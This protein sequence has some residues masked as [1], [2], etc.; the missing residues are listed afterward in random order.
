MGL[1]AFP[2]MPA[3]GV[4]DIVSKINLSVV[5]V[6]N[7]LAC[8]LWMSG[9]ARAAEGV[10]VRETFLKQYP[11]ARFYESG[12]RVTR[13]YGT[14]MSSG[15]SAE[16]SATHFVRRYSEMLGA[17]LADL[18]ETGPLADGRH[19]QG[20]MYDAATGT[21]KF[22][23]V[24]YTQRRGGIPVYESD[25]RLLVRN[26]EGHPLVLAANGL[27]DLGDFEV[28]PLAATAAQRSINS[29][30]AKRPELTRFSNPDLVIF[31]GVDDQIVVPR[32]AHRFVGDDGKGAGLV[33]SKWEVLADA[34]TGAILH[35][36]NLIADAEIDGSVSA[37]VSDGVGASDC[38]DLVEEP[39]PYLNVTSGGSSAEA[40]EFG[41]FTLT[42]LPDGVNTI[43]STLNGRYF[44]VITDVGSVSTESV[45]VSDGEVATILHDGSET[46]EDVLSQVNAYLHSNIARD[47]TLRF[48]PDY[49]VISDQFDFTVRTNWQGVICP[50]NAQYTGDVIRFCRQTSGC[51]NMA[52]SVVVHHEYGH[53]LVQTAGSGQG[54]Y[55]EGMGDTIGVLITDDPRTG[56]GFQGNCGSALRSA[57]NNMQ[58]PCK[59]PI[60]TC[61]TLLSGCVWDTRNALA[62][63]HP[64][65]FRDIISNLAIN[66]MLLHIGSSITPQIT[67][68][69]LTL[70]DDDAQLE[71]G[72]PHYAEIAEGFGL[73]NMDAPPLALLAFTYPD[74]VPSMADPA[75]G[76]PIRVSIEPVAG[77][78]DT[79]VAP[80]LNVSINGGPFEGS[81]MTAVGDDVYEASLPGSPCFDTIE[82]FVAATAQGGGQSTSPTAAPLNVFE[83]VV[84]TSITSLAAFDFEEDPAFSVVGNASEGTWEI[85]DPVGCNRGDPP[86]D[87][88]GSGQCWLTEN[89]PFGCNSDVDDGSTTFTT[90]AFDMGDPAAVYKVSYARWYSNTEGDSPNSDIFVVEISNDDGESWVNL[91]TVG[92]AGPEVDGG[93]FE[94]VHVVDNLLSPTDQMRVRFTAE[95]AAPGSVVEAAVDA[96][97]VEKFVCLV[98]SVS[99]GILHASATA[100]FSGYIDPRA[101][102]SDGVALDL[103]LTELT[104]EFSE[105]VTRMDGGV[106]DSTAFSVSTS[107][108]AELA[109]VSV[110]ARENPVMRLT[111]SD[112]IPAGQWVTVIAEVQDDAGNEISSFGDLGPGVD[113]P[114]RV[115]IAF[116][117]GDVDQSGDVTPLDLFTFRQYATGVAS[118]PAGALEDYLDMDRDGAIMPTDLFLYRQLINGVGNATQAWSGATLD[119]QRP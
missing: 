35:E 68:D 40:D 48:N 106:V 47:Y 89:D 108:D 85:G 110:D 90:T 72:T 73:H 6:L 86:S 25:L 91:E 62:Q 44:D 45:A 39:L 3:R 87:F 111:L 32:L 57:D 11:K 114:D 82:W 104:V 9:D 107:G 113:E 84:A 26:E 55:G 69:F 100:P 76:A 2:I 77:L 31:A 21:Y 95:D 112:P 93:W 117:P 23:L 109:V 119:S 8:A 41:A 46:D 75:D 67:I 22:T 103:G 16:E 38:H 53:H 18:S 42:D 81:A 56:V 5:F 63:S 116:L 66:A 29:A 10:A 24:Y 65:D 52:F 94:V 30:K 14:A 64:E 98:D 70:D 61:G 60:H 13:V 4:V 27:R 88:D 102:S 19:T 58:F 34:V 33:E 20:V 17:K 79:N 36:E 78:L 92:P 99:P 96:F 54:A 59:G 97:E 37:L 51:A 7:V 105:P 28:G 1:A 101:E 15:A 74:G 83:T 50:C 12:P 80:T 43:S 49:P 115:D 118:P 71:N